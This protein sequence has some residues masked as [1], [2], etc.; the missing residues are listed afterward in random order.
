[1]QSNPQTSAAGRQ[2]GA[3]GQPQAS[4]ARPQLVV[5][6]VPPELQEDKY[7]KMTE[8]ELLRFIQDP[9]ATV[10]QKN[11]ACRR[12]AVI[13]TRNAVVPLAALLSDEQVAQYARFALRPIP[14]PAVDD[15]LRAAIPKL[16]GNLLVGVINTIGGRGDVKAVDVLTRLMYGSDAGVA[17]AAAAALGRIGGP[18]GAKALQDALAK[19]KGDLRTEVGNA[20]LIAAEGFM[21]KGDRKQGLALYEVLSRAD[22]PKHVRL[23][24]MH[25]T[26]V[27]ET[28]FTRPRETPPK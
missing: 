11:I 2:P 25:A 20:A 26:L 23:G 3:P 9:G 10:F 15:A 28:M 24:A 7:L 27:A 6:P 14:D 17:L 12:L 19:T 18:G 21:N 1:M 16:K 13:G 8:P 22:M 5:P 4:V